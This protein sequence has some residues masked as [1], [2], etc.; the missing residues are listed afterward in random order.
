MGTFATHIF[1]NG[2]WGGTTA[3]DSWLSIDIH[4]SDIAT[5]EYSPAPTGLGKFYMGFQPRDYFEDPTASSDV[6][7]ASEATAFVAWA[8]QVL[9]VS[10]SADSLLPL[11]A[12]DSAEDPMD[13]FVGETVERL[14]TLLQLPVPTDWS[15]YITMWSSAV[16]DDSAG[17]E[18]AG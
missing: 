1:S 15:I 6:D 8:D 17:H 13:D 18:D 14:L 5:I 16:T 7:N 10:I 3:G 9:G 12:E 4:D 11:M 2:A